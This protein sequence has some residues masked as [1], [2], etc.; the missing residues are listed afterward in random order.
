[1]LIQKYFKLTSITPLNVMQFVWHCDGKTSNRQDGWSEQHSGFLLISIM[2][3]QYEAP[4]FLHSLQAAKGHVK[5]Y[6]TYNNLYFPIYATGALFSDDSITLPRQLK[7][8]QLYLHLHL[9]ALI[10]VE[11]RVVQV[12]EN[13]SQ[14][15]LYGST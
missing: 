8:K 5:E 7:G 14:S 6:E 1:M 13:N 9:C 3:S 12:S 10:I 11:L 15:T 2:D 4:I